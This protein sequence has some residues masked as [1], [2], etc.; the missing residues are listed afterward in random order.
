MIRT[1]SPVRRPPRLRRFT[2]PRTRPEIRPS[3]PPVVYGWPFWLAYASNLLIM[4]AVSL[5]F[6][7][8]DFV[9]LLGG[10]EFHLGWIV[11]VGMV[12]S[13]VMRFVL[14]SWI[15]HYGTRAVWLGS[16][17]LF[18]AACFAHMAVA[19]HA[20]VA[21]YLFRIL[22]CCAFAGIC[23]AS[24]TFVSG[25]GPTQRMAELLGVLGTA[26]F[27]G[28]I[29]GTSLGDFLLGS[30]TADRVQVTRMFT[31][32]GLLGTLAFPLAWFATWRETRPVQSFR[33]PLW[34]ALR[35]YHPGALLAVGAVMG[36]GLGLPTVFLRTYAAELNIPRIGLFFTAY[37]IVAIVTRVLTRRWPERFGT[38]PM[39][40]LGI[41]GL[42]FS[43]LLLLLVRGEWQ[44]V[45]P[46]I[47]FGFSHAVLFPS[48]MTAGNLAFPIQYRGLATV[49][50]LAMWDVGQLIGAPTA[51]AILQ[52]SRPLGLPPYPTMFVATAGLLA[53]VG[54]WY[55]V[56]SR[57]RAAAKLQ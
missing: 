54:V 41:G 9:T 28:T 50:V 25:R 45:L 21:I 38:R 27:I 51:G 24:M 18:V 17:L 22:Y 49:L 10:T 56:A 7:Y 11:G 5:L 6:R 23:G 19:S 1:A 46:G 44:L 36:M 34:E 53:L 3:E 14:G 57:G 8:A 31:A 48:V 30:V 20:G 55:A 29:A 26:G 15:D 43:V 12:G 47:G 16:L 32:A 2:Q 52:Y 13:L 35:R 40:L 4:V 33:L 39:I 42:A 37:S